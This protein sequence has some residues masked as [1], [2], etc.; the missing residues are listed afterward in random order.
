MGKN[1]GG[2]EVKEKSKYKIVKGKRRIVCCDN[3]VFGVKHKCQKE[4]QEKTHE[5]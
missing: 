5:K 2:E 4:P 1:T 3:G